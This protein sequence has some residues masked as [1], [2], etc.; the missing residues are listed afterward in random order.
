LTQYCVQKQTRTD[1]AC[2]SLHGEGASWRGPQ[3]FVQDACEDHHVCVAKQEGMCAEE[4]IY[5]L[6]SGGQERAQSDFESAAEGCILET[7]DIGPLKHTAD[8]ALAEGV[9]KL[10]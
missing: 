5:L 9:K 4:D 1:E 8:N 3:I 6:L 10:C 2:N 7:K